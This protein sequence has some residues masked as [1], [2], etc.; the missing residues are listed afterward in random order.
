VSGPVLRGLLGEPAQP[1]RA[2]AAG[3]AARHEAVAAA[4]RLSAAYPGATV[5][6]WRC[7][8]GDG[9]AAT[10][11]SV[12]VT[13]TIGEVSDWLAGNWAPAAAAPIAAA[14]RGPAAGGGP[15]SPAAGRA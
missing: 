3:L 10:V 14:G 4:G 11:G 15:G 7:R 12:T 13:G 9:L 5:E 1:G 6:P 8:D 2:H